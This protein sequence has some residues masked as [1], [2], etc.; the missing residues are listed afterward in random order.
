MKLT[1]EMVM[2]IRVRKKKQIDGMKKLELLESGQ[3]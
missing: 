2:K 3:E 1:I